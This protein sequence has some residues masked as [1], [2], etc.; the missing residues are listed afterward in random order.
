MISYAAEATGF[1]YS[2]KKRQ[3]GH[4]TCA[5]SLAAGHKLWERAP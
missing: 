3:T 4:A 5:D 2:N 1:N